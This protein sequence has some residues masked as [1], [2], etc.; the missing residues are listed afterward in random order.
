MNNITAIIL[1]GLVRITLTHLK[2][3][4]D[5]FRDL[6]VKYFIAQGA[7]LSI[8]RN[9]SLRGM[10]LPDNQDLDVY[11]LKEDEPENIKKKAIEAGWLDRL[12]ESGFNGDC[13]TDFKFIAWRKG[14]DDICA[15]DV[16]FLFKFKNYRWSAVMDKYCLYDDCLFNKSRVLKFKDI[17]VPL[18]NPPE[19]YLKQEYGEDWD[20]PKI[21]HLWN[22]PSVRRALKFN[23]HFKLK[24]EDR[25]YNFKPL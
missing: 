8:V 14:G 6:G 3:V 24:E 22:Y 11:V 13:L 9:N 21:M 4:S 17:Y 25:F 10:T 5:F 12:G 7:C 23:L 1:D 2:W 20:V 18:P 19:E 15:L 16:H